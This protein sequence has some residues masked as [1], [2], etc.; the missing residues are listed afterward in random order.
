[1][2][3]SSNFSSNTPSIQNEMK[4]YIQLASAGHFPLFFTEWIEEGLE[5]KQPMSY[6]IANRNVR[7]VFKN[8]SRHKTQQKKKTALIGLDKLERDVFVQSFVKVVEHSLLKDL[9]NLH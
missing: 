8:L 2:T 6:Q 1:M 4:S 5:S 9:K 3:T 7:D